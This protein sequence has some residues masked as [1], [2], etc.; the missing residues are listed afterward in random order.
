MTRTADEPRA[1]GKRPP[2]GTLPDGDGDPELQH[3]VHRVRSEIGFP[4]ALLSRADAA[5]VV[6][7]RVATVT[8]IAG[9]LRSLAE[10]LAAGASHGIDGAVTLRRGAA[11]IALRA[12]EGSTR[13]YR[14]TAAALSV[15]APGGTG[16]SVEARRTH[17]AMTWSRATQ[18]AA[19]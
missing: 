5:A 3:I 18:R 1:P 9:A 8:G 14:A 12:P 19:R 10:G 16:F 7:T 11:E 4:M 15:H 17:L 6:G 2:S 13:I